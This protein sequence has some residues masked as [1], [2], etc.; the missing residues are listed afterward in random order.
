MAP[1]PKLQMRCLGT[2]LR[3]NKFDGVQCQSGVNPRRWHLRV[4]ARPWLQRRR[5]EF[6][7]RPLKQGL[8]Q[9][10]RPPCHPLLQRPTELERAFDP[11]CRPAD[12]LVRG[13]R[14]L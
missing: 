14:H 11:E 8:R 10:Q 6:R 9:L 4:L 7:D 3:G 1:R 5:H 2:C 12:N 13:Q